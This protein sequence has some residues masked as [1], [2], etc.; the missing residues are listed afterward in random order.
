MSQHMCSVPRCRQAIPLDTLM[1]R[2]H[3]RMVPRPIQT[4]VYQ[5]WDRYQAGRLSLADLR[6]TPALPGMG[7]GM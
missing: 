1:C 3:W 5:A 2:T 6:K 7:G 4:R